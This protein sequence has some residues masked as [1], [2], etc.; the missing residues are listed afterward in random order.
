MREPLTYCN[1]MEYSEHNS[2]Y[3]QMVLDD[4]YVFMSGIVAP[5]L[6]DGEKALGDTEAETR[7]IMTAIREL[8]TSVGLGMEDVVR[9]DVHLVDFEDFDGMN[10][11]YRSFFKEG[12]FPARTTVQVARLAGGGRVEITCMARRR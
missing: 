3:S 5:D 7:V 1:E 12:N 8:L 6:P 9:S 4:N 10:A 11:V 2:P